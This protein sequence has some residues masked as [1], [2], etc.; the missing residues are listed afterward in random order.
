MYAFNQFFNFVTFFSL[1]EKNVFQHQMNLVSILM[2]IDEC[3]P[4]CG[5]VSSLSIVNW[6]D[7]HLPQY[8]AAKKRHNFYVKRGKYF[9]CKLTPTTQY[10]QYL[11]QMKRTVAFI[12]LHTFHLQS[13]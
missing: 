1:R 10:L 12:S 3:Q 13:S 8:S 2:N 5:Q 4:K 6:I 7:R 11:H 9:E